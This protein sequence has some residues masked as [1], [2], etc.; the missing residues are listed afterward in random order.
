MS[1]QLSNLGWCVVAQIWQGKKIKSK[2]LN[3]LG[4][5]DSSI[6]QTRISHWR[7]KQ[8]PPAGWWQ[9][10]GWARI[11]SS[12][13]RGSGRDKQQLPPIGAEY[14]LGAQTNSDSSP[15]DVC[16]SRDWEI[17]IYTTVYPRS[18]HVCSQLSQNHLFSPSWP[19]TAAFWTILENRLQ[20]PRSEVSNTQQPNI[21]W[22]QT[23]CFIKLK[24]HRVL[25]LV[26]MNESGVTKIL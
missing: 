20:T 8:H 7:A 2:S 17:W 1:F 6:K 3:P 14:T 5:L 21:V 25:Q 26:F 12:G 4:S 16:A 15:S 24:K 9:R 19:S 23:H 22:H 10:W 13:E 11:S 18:A